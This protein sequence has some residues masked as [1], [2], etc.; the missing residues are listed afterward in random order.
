MGFDKITI[1]LATIPSREKMLEEVVKSLSPQADMVCVFLNGYEKVPEFLHATPNV[2]VKQSQDYDDLADNGKFY[3]EVGG[4][5]LT[6]DDDFNYPTDYVSRLVEK[7]DFYERRAVVGVH[8]FV[9]IPPIKSFYK[10][11]NVFHYNRALAEDIKVD[12]IGTGTMGYHT[13]AIRFPLELFKTKRMADIW[14]GLSCLEKG[15]PRYCINRKDRW[16]SSMGTSDG[17]DIYTTFH[18]NDN[19]QTQLVTGVQW[20]R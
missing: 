17:S 13:S 7:I 18:A 5:H 15:V 12:V 14:V 10:S 20:T 9:F 3:W 1:T 16:L 8:G 19:A 6:V 11:R 4:Y 2:V